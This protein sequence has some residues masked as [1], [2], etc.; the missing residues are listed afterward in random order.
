VTPPSRGGPPGA[1]PRDPVQ[2]E[3]II[4]PDVLLDPARL[5][6]H[7]CREAR[8]R[9][10][11][12]VDVRVIRRSIDARRG[13][14]RVRVRVELHR[15][16]PPDAREPRPVELPTLHGEPEVVIVGAGPAGLFAALRLAERGIRAQV[17]ERGRDV[18]RRR[19]DVA[20]LSQRGALD[21]DSN[22]CFGEGGA[23]T[24]SD[25]KLYT[26]SGKR[27]P[28]R[29]VLE[30]FVAY[31]A[32][33]EI[34]VDA[35]PHIG[36]NR[37]PGVVG[38]MRE[39]LESAGQQVRF[40]AR[41]TEL[42]RDGERV[43]G[44][45]LHDG[46]EVSARAVLMATGHSAADVYA[47]L[48]RAGVALSPKPFAMGVRVEH[49]QA[50]IDRTQFG[51][52]AGHPA[53]GAAAYRLV[54]HACDR[55]I[56]SFCMCPGGYIAPAAT[57]QGQQVVNGWSPSTRRGRFA[58]SGLVVEVSAA[59]LAEAGFDPDDP[60]SGLA[61]QRALERRAYDAGGGHFV[62]PAQRLG[63]LIAGRSSSSLPRIS[64]PRGAISARLDE[65][66][67]TLAPPLRAALRAIDRKLPGFAGPEGVAVGVESRTSAPL[68]VPR[69]RKTLQAGGLAGL[70]P[71]AEGAGYA[72]GIMSAALDGLR[73]AD[74]IALR[75]T[76]ATRG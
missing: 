39:H 52:L 25:G 35:R 34:L 70:Y 12:V 45:R 20:A 33:P 22:Y 65:V 43:R 62:A 10:D 38:R 55:S 64:Y 67:Q 47:M 46:S 36:T 17:L 58:N 3:L 71:A 7:A 9:E 42:L 13:K 1:T 60:L 32:A 40:D 11:R 57:L 69:D 63:D 48:H 53:L 21:P 8:V 50:F 31:G 24:F 15:A 61:F 14:P 19:R 74:A 30:T 18:S 5:R 2:V 23:G 59:T 44:V 76:R 4:H 16:A 26:R 29:D 75:T 73:I 66:L 72:G 54:E 27:G 28:V 6:E 49:P 51:E 68:R 37:L 41:V 56:F